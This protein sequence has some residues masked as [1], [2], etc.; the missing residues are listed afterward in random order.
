[1]KRKI[2]G[3][4]GSPVTEGNVDTFLATILDLAAEEGLETEN[5][6][7]AGLDIKNCRHCN[8]C[9]ARQKT[10]RY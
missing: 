9:L 5:I 6:S 1:M 7:L 3:I 8:F 2:I 10:G 4:S